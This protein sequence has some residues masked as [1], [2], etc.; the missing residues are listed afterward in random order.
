MLAWRRLEELFHAAVERDAATR[1]AYLDEACGSDAALR[2]EVES[3][4]AARGHLGSFI[5]EPVGTPDDSGTGARATL[6]PG[7]QL[8]PYEIIEFIGAGGMGEVYRARDPRLGR[9]VAVKVLP[10]TVS[11]DAER[12]MRFE[13]EARAAATLNHPGILA[14]H[15]VG[16]QQGSP[17]IVSELLEGETLRARMADGAL[18]VRNALELAL[19]LARALAAAHEKGIVHRDLKPENV[20]LTSDGR[21]K[22]LDFG[23]AKLLPTRESEIARETWTVSGAV[24]GTTA[25]M[26]PEQLRGHKTDV[27]TD[28]FSFGVLLFEMLAGRRPFLGDSAADVEAAILQHDPPR[29]VDLDVPLSPLLE[30]IT[31]RC[32]QKKPERRFPSA[33]EVA[34]ALE[35]ISGA[36]TASTLSNMAARKLRRAARR[37][38]TQVAAVLLIVVLGGWVARRSPGQLGARESRIRSLAVLPLRN[39]SG[40]PAQDFF[41]DGMQ[42]ALTNAVAKIHGLRVISRTSAMRYKGSD[43]PLSQIG[44]ELTVDA[45]IEGSVLEQG[46]RVRITAQLVDVSTDSHLWAETYE[47]SLRDVLAVHDDLARTIATRIKAV[48]TPEDERRL[49]GAPRVDPE[50]YREY[51]K[52]NFHI[53]GTG[54]DSIRRAIE[55]YQA[56]IAKDPSYAPAYAGLSRAYS[57][58]G[59]FFGSMSPREAVPKAKGAALR[60]L[61]LNGDLAEGHFA[62]AD[63]S[64]LFEWDWPAAESSF[65]K[66]LSLD[67]GVIWGRT[68]YAAYLSAMMRF[69]ESIALG[70]ETLDLDPLSVTAYNELAHSL[71]VA[72]RYDEA[73]GYLR[74]SYELAPTDFFTV[75]FLAE[76]LT[77]TG[78][79]QEAIPYLRKAETLAGPKQAIGLF[80]AYAFAGACSDA[81]RLLE[82]MDRRSREEMPWPNPSYYPLA[83][84]CVPPPGLGRKDRVIDG[85]ERMYANRDPVLVLIRQTWAD[86]VGLSGEPR[87]EALLRRMRL[88]D[89]HLHGSRSPGAGDAGSP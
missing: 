43:R 45:V 2:K 8:G 28:V 47:R 34:V 72:R 78:R 61:E 29:L 10:E 58:D 21:V 24:L 86:A 20:F 55:H 40:D 87:F 13:Q 69:E 62:L 26:S 63:I 74:K 16:W 66:G 48:L 88:D 17:Y 54:P 12:R 75:Q 83:K 49:S 80:A 37:P 56:A 60:A 4:I 7:L 39:L 82:G 51:L 76:L 59:A 68:E 15:D 19:P 27:R 22:V 71:W 1:A 33:G 89:G 14:I 3:L 46:N 64:Y 84:P 53:V 23:L 30:R 77:A 18:S 85:L 67:P 36:E 73:L 42:E 6:P 9:D 31:E 38:S 35:A 32:L 70:R 81:S 44:R 79:S 5:A 50:A 52:G 41:A 65:R 11:G 57:S 25:Y